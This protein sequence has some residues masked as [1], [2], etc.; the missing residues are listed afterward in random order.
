M[1]Y[2]RENLYAKYTL[3]RIL[4]RR[5]TIP[6]IAIHPA[7]CTKDDTLLVEISMKCFTILVF[8]PLIVELVIVAVDC[9][10][11]R[12]Y[13]WYVLRCYKQ[14]PNRILPVKQLGRIKDKL[15]E[16]VKVIRAVR[17]NLL[18]D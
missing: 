6:S 16:R 17:A 7:I 18:V 13:K 1:S 9:S 3:Y 10:R 4:V 2:C 11:G 12:F 8:V 5:P 15:V 14:H